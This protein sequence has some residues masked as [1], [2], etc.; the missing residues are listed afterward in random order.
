MT[1]DE[2]IQEYKDEAEGQ[3]RAAKSLNCIE[4][5][6]Y[7]EKNEQIAEWLEELKELRSYKE[8]MEMQYLD[9][10][11]N[12]LEPLKLTSALESELFKYNYRKEHKP[13]DINILDYTIMYALKHCLEEQ[14]ED[15]PSKESE[16]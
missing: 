3:R 15:H 12:P 1:I 16:D 2:V 8:K 9:D 4:L 13:Q 14:L 6:F 7:A 10:I 5:D 11:S